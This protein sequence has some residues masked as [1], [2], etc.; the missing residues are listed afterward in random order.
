M[1]EGNTNTP[2]GENIEQNG[3]ATETQQ[4]NVVTPTSEEVPNTLQDNSPEQGSTGPIV[5]VA[6]IVILLIAGGIYFWNT[7][8]KNSTEQLQVIQSNEEADTIVNQL[9]TQ[10]TSDEIS[11]IEEDLGLTDFENLDSEL[12]ALLNEF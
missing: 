12:D 1:N 4:D 3:T 2:N 10:A 8:T 5:G 11:S 7:T 6:I 9:E